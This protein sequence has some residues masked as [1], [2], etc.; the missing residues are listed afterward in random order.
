MSLALLASTTISQVENVPHAADND[1]LFEHIVRTWLREV[2]DSEMRELVESAAV[3]RYFNQELLSILLGKPVQTEQFQ[4]LASFSFVQRID[5]GWLL[6]ELL[7]EAI[8]ND[9]RLRMPERYNQL[10]KR[11]VLYYSNK[12]KQSARKKSVS[13]ENAEFLYY[14]GNQFVQFLLKGHWISY[15]VEPLSQSNWMEAEQYIERRRLTVKAAQIIFVNQDTH[16]Q[17]SYLL[18]EHE[19]LQ[20]LNQIRFKELYELDTSCLKLIRNAK[21]DINGII[22]IIPI[23]ERTMDYLLTE[24]LSSPYFNALS[25]TVR[26]DLMVTENRKSG[27]FVKTLD[28]FDFSDIAMMHASLTTLINHILTTGYIVAAPISNPISHAICTSLGLDKVEGIFHRE[29]DGITPTSYYFLDTRGNKVLNYVNKMIASF[30][31]Q[32]DD[33]KKESTLDEL[34]QREKEVVER[35]LM[36]RSNLEVAMDL[37][38]SEA[39]VKKHISNIFQKLDVK[40]RS[41]LIHKVSRPSTLQ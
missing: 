16:T 7:R 32:E 3:A 27:F 33:E 38:I 25:E 36:G 13:W 21:G 26:Q 17:E 39:T 35:L 4:Q 30:G 1:V 19:S 29:Y 9:L 10:W 12:L 6:H 40:S 20:V 22:E 24:P 11:C 23:N 14:I 5:R 28:V 2:P 18:T 31:L 34:T 15:S 8:A 37:V 41:Q